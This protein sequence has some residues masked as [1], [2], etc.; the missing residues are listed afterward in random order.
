[1]ASFDVSPRGHGLRDKRPAWGLRP[2]ARADFEWAF[3]LHKEALGEYVEQSWG[4]EDDR[5]R[6]M[7]SEGFARRP[8]QVIEVIGEDVGGT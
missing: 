4:W 2:I 8:R 3:A 7:F 1:M 5:Q 6:Q